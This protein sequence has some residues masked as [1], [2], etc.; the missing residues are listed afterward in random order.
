MGVQ[1]LILPEWIHDREFFSAKV[2]IKDAEK[3]YRTVSVR[4]I[5][6]QAQRAWLVS[7]VR[8]VEGETRIGAALAGPGFDLNETAIVTD[9]LGPGEMDI[10]QFPREHHSEGSVRL[11]A[12]SAT[13]L[14][15]EASVQQR[16]GYLV[17]DIAGYPGWY[18]TV[19]GKPQRLHSTD[20]G[21][22]GLY[23]N[24][25]IHKIS[26]VYAPSCYKIGCFISLCGVLILI[27]QCAYSMT[28]AHLD[29]L[30]ARKLGT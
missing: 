20:G 14:Q 28:L 8:H 18:A 29:R 15:I 5:N 7:S 22:T 25:G 19:D 1:W 23:V 30:R 6:K 16:A 10:N 17:V 13:S 2:T 24:Q 4:K 26:I 11:R 3:H 9:H 21:V 12:Y 27:M